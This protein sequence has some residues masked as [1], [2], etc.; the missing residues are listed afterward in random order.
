[1]ESNSLALCNENNRLVIIRCFFVKEGQ[2]KGKFSIY[3]CP[4]WKMLATY[5]TNPLQGILLNVLREIIMV[6]KYVNEPENLSPPPSNERVEKLIKSKKRLF[7]L[8]RKPT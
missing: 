4:T 8:I 6:W 3:Y 1:M 5:F 7:H 2:D